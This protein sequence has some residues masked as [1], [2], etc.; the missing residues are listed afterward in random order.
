MNTTDPTPALGVEKES[1]KSQEMVQYNDGAVN[2]LFAEQ[3]DVIAWDSGFKY[4][5]DPRYGQGRT[6]VRTKSG[7][8]Y[9][10]GDGLV[11]NV[12]KMTVYDLSHN[13][14]ET[15]DIVIGQ[16]WTIPGFMLHT[17]DIEN[18]EIEYKIAPKE[19]NGSRQINEPNPFTAAEEYLE[20]ARKHFDAAGN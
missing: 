13:L 14:E 10:L 8:C 16:S 2:L 7:N 4:A 11:V 17:S 5:N 20:A 19:W 3:G 15:P 6:I 1:F 9:I 18:V 12:D